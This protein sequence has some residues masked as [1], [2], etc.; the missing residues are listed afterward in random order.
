MITTSI[1]WTRHNL[2]GKPFDVALSLLVIPS[3]LWLAYSIFDWALT[4][5]R[6]DIIAASLRVLMIG[7]FPADQAWRAWTASAIIGAILGAGLGCVFSFKPHHGLVLV[8]VPLLLLIVDHGDLGNALPA[9]GVVAATVLGWVLTSYLPLS[10]KVMPAAAFTGFIVV[11]AVMA[12]PGVGLWG[13]LLLSVLL[14]LV[15]SVRPFRSASCLRSDG[16]A[17]SPACGSFAPGI[18]RS[19][20]RSRLSSSSTGSGSSCRSLHRS[21]DWPTS[22]AA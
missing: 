11:V 21:G 8:L 20:A 14:T 10:R 4:T 19:C 13:G 15:T 2:F 6:W 9:A 7:V 18:S 3:V 17:G 16:R 22:R 1:K 12:P 5:A